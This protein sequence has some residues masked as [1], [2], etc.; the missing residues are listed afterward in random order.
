MIW[1]T[2][3][4]GVK[5]FQSYMQFCHAVDAVFEKTIQLISC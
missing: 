3:F 4:V 2:I 1:F 5:K